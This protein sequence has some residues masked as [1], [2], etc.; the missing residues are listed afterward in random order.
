MEALRQSIVQGALVVE[1]FSERFSEQQDQPQERA[2]RPQEGAFLATEKD[3]TRA[4]QARL[5]L[6]Q[7]TS[8]QG[9][10]NKPSGNLTA[11]PERRPRLLRMTL[12]CDHGKSREMFKRNDSTSWAML[13]RLRPTTRNDN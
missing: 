10:R 2:L 7:F 1:R 12:P 5:G 3:R 9:S 6:R 13:Q 4:E 11:T 8:L